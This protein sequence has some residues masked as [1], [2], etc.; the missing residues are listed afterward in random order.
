MKKILVLIFFATFAILSN[1]A[2]AQ[3]DYFGGGI[4]LATGGEYKYDGLLYYNNSFGID[5]RK[6]NP[7]SFGICISRNIKSEK[8][9]N[10]S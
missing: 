7:S 4:A 2:K 3:F 8:I 9:F 1:K 5:L 6:A 10:F